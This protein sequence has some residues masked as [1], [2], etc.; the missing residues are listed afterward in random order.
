MLVDVA[1]LGGLGAWLLLDQNEIPP[2]ENSP[3][4]LPVGKRKRPEARS[5]AYAGSLVCAQCH[6]E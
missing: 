5:N 6:E 1:I 2:D 3:D 4:T